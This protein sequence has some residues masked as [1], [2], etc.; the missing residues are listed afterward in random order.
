VRSSRILDKPVKIVYVKS[1]VGIVSP[2]FL[3]PAL[4]QPGAGGTVKNK[5][6]R[7][8]ME[9]IIQTS[10]VFF[11]QVG[12]LVAKQ[13]CLILGYVLVGSFILWQGSVGYIFALM[14]HLFSKE[15]GFLGSALLFFRFSLCLWRLILKPLQDSYFVSFPADTLSSFKKGKNFLKGFQWATELTCDKMKGIIDYAIA[16]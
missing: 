4:T 15:V 8:R 1:G 7:G 10:F 16:V 9:F 12:V 5:G 11:Y 13:L 6:L 2:S 14:R 3:P